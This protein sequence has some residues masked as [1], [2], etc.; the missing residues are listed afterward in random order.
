MRRDIG[1]SE[2]LRHTIENKSSMGDRGD[3]GSNGNEMG[4]SC[5][6]GGKGTLFSNIGSDADGRMGM[7]SLLGK[8]ENGTEDGVEEVRS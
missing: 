4:D 1:S 2:Q 5:G 3:W 6:E 8:I 7:R